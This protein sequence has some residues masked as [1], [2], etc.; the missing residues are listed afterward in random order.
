MIDITKLVSKD[1][2]RWVE[3]TGKAQKGRI[4][5]FTASFIFVVF[6][7][8]DNW[9]KYNEYVAIPVN[10]DSLTFLN[11]VLVIQKVEI[12]NEDLRN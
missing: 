4:K 10:P 11:K 9:N 7:C 12:A 5:F 8:E 6:D 2:G 3:L 1:I